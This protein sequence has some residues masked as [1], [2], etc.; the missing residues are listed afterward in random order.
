F[1]GLSR[2][3]MF[4]FGIGD[5]LLSLRFPHGFPLVQLV[6][7]PS[8]WSKCSEHRQNE[9]FQKAGQCFELAMNVAREAEQ[10]G[11]FEDW[12]PPS[13]QMVWGL[14]SLSKG[15][16]LIAEEALF[17]EVP[18][19]EEEP[20]QFL[21]DNYHRL[22]DGAG[23]KPFSRDHDYEESRGRIESELFSEEVSTLSRH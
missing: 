9:Y 6:R 4:A 20:L 12:S 15:A 11:D 22:L 2:E 21:F 17:R 16:H 13:E 10:M 8:I 18:H 19:G 23:W 1:D 5:R 7:L 14:V 3:R